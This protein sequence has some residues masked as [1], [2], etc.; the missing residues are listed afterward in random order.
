MLSGGPIAVGAIVGA[1]SLDSIEKRM[2]PSASYRMF[3]ARF[4]GAG[5]IAGL[6]LSGAV[7]GAAFASLRK[8]PQ[9]LSRRRY[10]LRAMCCGA[11]T[12]VSGFYFSILSAAFWMP[13]W[14]QVV[15]QHITSSHSGSLIQMVL[16]SFA[17][18][19]LSVA[20]GACIVSF[21]AGALVH[22]VSNRLFEYAERLELQ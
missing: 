8:R 2:F 12:G 4:S 20:G 21:A 7:L 3:G 13:W 11:I 22:A 15:D 14:M 5:L 16:T 17:E 19:M 18:L 9:H 1:F 10:Y 6:S